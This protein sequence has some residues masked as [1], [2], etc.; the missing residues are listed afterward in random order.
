MGRGVDRL[1][2][3]PLLSWQERILAA[4]AAF[5]LVAAIPVT[6]EIGFAL[7]IVFLA[8]QALRR[9]RAARA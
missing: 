5:F 6:D 2:P 9:R 1:L 4:A 8:W 3:R 7:G